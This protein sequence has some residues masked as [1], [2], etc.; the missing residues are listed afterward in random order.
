LHHN[1]VP[2]GIGAKEPNSDRT[3]P[4]CHSGKYVIKRGVRRNKSGAVQRLLCKRCGVKFIPRTGFERMKH[5]S[6][7]VLVSLDLFFK[8]LSLTK[9]ADHLHQFHDTDVSD[10]TVYR[11]IRKYVILMSRRMEDFKP[12]LS[13]RWHTDETLLKVNGNKEY[14]WN[15]LDSK[16]RFLIATQ[17]TERRNGEEAR[18]IVRESMER[19]ERSPGQWITDGLPSYK[20]A[21]NEFDRKGKTAHISGKGFE[22]KMN[23]NKIERFHATVKERTKV[24]RGFR[25]NQNA[26]LFA[27]GYALYY[28][29]VRPHRSLKGKTPAEAAG[30]KKPDSRNRWLGLL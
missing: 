8:G 7:A 23:N 10:T 22:G 5:T 2:D 6:L 30:M 27:K 1:E 20:Q 19:T 11:W 12:Q 17:V 15:T 21:R 9:I 3:C 26:A 4:R 14:M 29:H 24:M 25:S 16:T 18:R 28:N 13:R